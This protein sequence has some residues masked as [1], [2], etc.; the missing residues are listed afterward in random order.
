[1]EEIGSIDGAT[2]CGFALTRNKILYRGWCLSYTIRF[3]Y[4][5]Q[6]TTTPF[7]GG[8]LYYKIP[9]GRSV[10]INNFGEVTDLWI[11]R[12]RKRIK[13]RY[14]NTIISYPNNEINES[15]NA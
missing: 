5:D 12:R 13:K 2:S 1:M 9:E 3:I 7:L 14:G 10:K 4:T 8:D 6:A 15:S 11:C